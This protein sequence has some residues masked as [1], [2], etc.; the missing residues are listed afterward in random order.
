MS[1]FTLR[2]LDVDVVLDL[3]IHDLDIVLALAHAESKEI[4]AAGI[5]MLSP[6]VDIANVRLEFADGCIANLTASRV[7]TEKVR[8]LRLFQPRQYISLDYAKQTAALFAVGGAKRDCLRTAA[9]R[10]RRAVKAAVRRLSRCRR[11]PST[12]ETDMALRRVEH[13]R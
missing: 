5:S 4:R 1:V 2:S 10:I 13:W 9:H 6:K 3:M 12:A 11:E 8:K 7:S